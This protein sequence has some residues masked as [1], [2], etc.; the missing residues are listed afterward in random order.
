MLFGRKE[1]E[2]RRRIQA[3]V[4]IGLCIWKTGKALRFASTEVSR[5][6]GRIP[7]QGK[8]EIAGVAHNFNLMVKKVE[9]Q[10]R[11]LAF[12]IQ[13]RFIVYLSKQGEEISL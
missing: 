13:R 1:S 11:Q 3:T 4:R 7:V 6:S 2:M 12:L 5:P 10:I 8:D 9:R